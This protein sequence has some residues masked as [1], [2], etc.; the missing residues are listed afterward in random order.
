MGK[1]FLSPFVHEFVVTAFSPPQRGAV[2]P[3]PKPLPGLLSH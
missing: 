1:R 3:T 2:K